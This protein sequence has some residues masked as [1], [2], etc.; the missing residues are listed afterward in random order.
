MQMIG[1]MSPEGYTRDELVELHK[2]LAGSELIDLPY[3]DQEAFPGMRG[4]V[5]IIRNGVYS[6][7]ITPKQ[8]F[9]EQASLSYDTKKFMYGRVVNKLARHNICFAGFNQEPDYENG[10]GRVVKIDYLTYLKH[11]RDHLHIM[12]GEK[13]RGLLVEGNFY[14]DTEK[15]GISFHGDSERKIVIG[16]RVPSCL[17]VVSSV[18]SRRSKIHHVS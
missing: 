5:L 13:G 7:K 2:N 11:V 12:C 18:K 17:S 9:D 8:M 10:K 4:T 6:F 1:D 16:R 3:P 15:T 14:Y